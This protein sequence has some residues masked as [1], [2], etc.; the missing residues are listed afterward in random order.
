MIQSV[1]QFLSALT[2]WQKAL[3]GTGVFVL[4][5]TASLLAVGYILVKIPATY[6]LDSHRRESWD[7]WPAWLRWV[8]IGL[9]NL[10]GVALIVFGVIQLFTPGQGLLTILI[11]VVLIDFPGK[12]QLERKIVG[13]PKVLA[14]IN[15]L[16]ARYGRPPLEL[17]EQP[18]TTPHPRD[19]ARAGAA[20]TQGF[21]TS[22][23]SR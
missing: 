6:F 18:P 2:W 20:R 17:E 23:L 15:Q 1:L 13:R 10:F 11:G 9:K 21:S 4:T 19:A 22:E 8:A 5:F 14:A 16:R 12:R 3:L 7:H